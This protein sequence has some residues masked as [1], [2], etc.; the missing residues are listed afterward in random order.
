MANKLSKDVILR[1][2]AYRCLQIKGGLNF[3]NLERYIKEQTN[4]F[5]FIL[6]SKD[7]K[8]Q[9]LKEILLI[10]IQQQQTLKVK[11]NNAK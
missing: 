5:K 2:I 3:D 6:N 1:I 9:E 4:D 7:S 8:H 11:G 10:A